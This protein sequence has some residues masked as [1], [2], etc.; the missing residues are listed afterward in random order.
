MA[1]AGQVLRWA[2]MSQI[3]LDFEYLRIGQVHSPCWIAGPVVNGETL[4][5]GYFG[6]GSS[7]QEAKEA[8]CRK[9]AFSGH[10]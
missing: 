4:G 1:Y 7:K 5:A 10:C 8:A 6:Y 9:M 3:P 2:H